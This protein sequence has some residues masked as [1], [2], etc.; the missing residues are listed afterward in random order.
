MYHSSI[1]NISVSIW[2]N[3]VS[4]QGETRYMHRSPN[5]KKFGNII[6][7]NGNESKDTYIKINKHS[8]NVPYGDLWGYYNN[9]YYYY[10]DCAG[11]VRHILYDIDSRLMKP[12]NELSPLIDIEKGIARVYPRAKTFYT[13]FTCDVN[14]KFDNIIREKIKTLRNEL[15]E[16][17]WIFFVPSRDYSNLKPGDIMVKNLKLSKN[18]GHMGIFIS[19]GKDSTGNYINVLESS[20]SHRKIKNLNDLI[21]EYNYYMPQYKIY[22]KDFKNNNI[23][24]I[25]DLRN[26]LI[27]YNNTDTLIKTELYNSFNLHQTRGI[28]ALLAT[29][30]GIRLSKWRWNNVKNYIIGRINV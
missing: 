19:R 3:L 16:M 28:A 7:K 20:S 5:S 17:G 12:F 1:A 9:G 29:N 24:N 14:Y 30:G 2:K 15:I 4:G 6:P 8:Y 13:L 21:K 25:K 26:A 27:L 18:T 23:K 11:L 10:L 22:K